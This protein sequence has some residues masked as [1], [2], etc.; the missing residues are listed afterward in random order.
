[1][2][3]IPQVLSTTRVFRGRV[4]NVRID[5]LSYGDGAKHRIDVVEHG[6][7]FAI[8]AMPSPGEV[9]LVRQYR[10]A[11]GSM[12]WEIPAGRS[13]A[14]EDARSGASRELREETGYRAGR[15]RPLASVYTTPGFCDEIL[16][17]F[18]AD[19]LEAGEQALDE[20]ER[21]EVRVFTFDAVWRLVADGTIA[22]GKT[23]LALL[24]AQANPGDLAGG[25]PR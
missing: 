13:E 21:I 16:H 4:F 23:V 3:D 1:M 8:L 15:M 18:H 10:H 19:E 9:V 5:E 7:S 24:W 20:D 6:A 17:F 22:D 2:S 12:L 11:A 14:G 25:F